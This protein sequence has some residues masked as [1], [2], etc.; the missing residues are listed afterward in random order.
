MTDPLDPL[1][2]W[3]PFNTSQ[4]GGKGGG[5]ELPG[6]D[7]WTNSGGDPGYVLSG[8]NNVAA[9]GGKYHGGGGGGGANNN[10]SLANG[11]VGT[12]YGAGGGGGGGSNPSANGGS[13]ATGFADIIWLEA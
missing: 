3:Y 4:K 2:L 5:P 10:N 7:G 13:G 9:K 1:L 12:G 8:T 11:L 6:E